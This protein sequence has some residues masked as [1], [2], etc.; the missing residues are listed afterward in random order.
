MVSFA[1]SSM[2]GL[3][4]MVATCGLG[5]LRPNTIVLP[6]ERARWVEVV[7]VRRRGR[8]VS[9]SVEILHRL[10]GMAEA[11]LPLVSVV[12]VRRGRKA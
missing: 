5:A 12:G 7:G 2:E 3:H 11:E 1:P 8:E 9:S 4:D 10:R 6:L